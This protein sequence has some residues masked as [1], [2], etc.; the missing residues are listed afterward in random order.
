MQQGFESHGW[1]DQGTSRRESSLPRRPLRGRG[2]RP[3]CPRST[4]ISLRGTR[5]GETTLN[6]QVE[7]R[8]ALIA[9]QGKGR[10]EKRFD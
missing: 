8:D 6:E 5:K 4:F 1:V 2:G 9:G 10:E 3:K 7:K